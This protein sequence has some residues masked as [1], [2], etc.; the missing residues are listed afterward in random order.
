MA[1]Q[2][3]T[4]TTTKPTATKLSTG[5]PTKLTR[6]LIDKAAGYLGT[7]VGVLPTKEG[8]ALYLNISRSTVY[9]W[10]ELDTPLGRSFSDIFENI[11]AEQGMRLINGGLY[12]RFNPTITKLMLTKHDYTDRVQT[13]LTT[14]GKDLPMPILGGASSNNL[15]D[16]ISE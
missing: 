6:E 1:K 4:A 9:E 8:F 7:C 15:T 10:I 16:D 11:M 14:N 3:K 12:G 5:R 2:S 13:D